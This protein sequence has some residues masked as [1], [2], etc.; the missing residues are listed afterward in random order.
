VLFTRGSQ[1]LNCAGAVAIELLVMNIL[2][3]ATGPGEIRNLVEGR[4]MGGSKGVRA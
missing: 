3:A 2:D 1:G 4:G